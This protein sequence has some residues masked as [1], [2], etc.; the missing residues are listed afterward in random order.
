[1]SAR[2]AAHQD[3]LHVRQRRHDRVPQVS[4]TRRLKRSARRP[5][6]SIRC[7]STARPSKSDYAPIRTSRRSTPRSSWAS[8]RR[9]RRSTSTRRSRP[10]A[11]LQKTMGPPC[12]GRSACRLLRKAAAV[13]RAPQIRDRR[14][15][16]P[17]G[18]QE[19]AGG[20]GRRR[21]VR[22]PDRLL[23][24]DRRGQRRLRQAPGQAP[25]RTRTRARSCARSACSPASRPF[26][27]PMALSTGMSA[28]AL[29]AGNAVVYKP[30]QDTPWTGLML[31]ECYRAAGLPR[32]AFSTS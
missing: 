17:G 2:S 13:I 15:H 1:M 24:E 19:P 32:R 11:R 30:S 31:Y 8:S 10:R 20:H 22:R 5:E 21:G 3:H 4:S 23:R 16:E 14:G 12:P 27:F 25:A 26:N 7:A 6:R 18:R 29:L 9:R 28:A